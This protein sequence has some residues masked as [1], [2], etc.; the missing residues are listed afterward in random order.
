MIKENIIAMV[1]FITVSFCICAFFCVYIRYYFSGYILTD[2][3]Q[4]KSLNNKRICAIIYYYS[5]NLYSIFILVPHGDLSITSLTFFWFV[6]FIMILNVF[7]IS[8]LET[9]RRYKKRKKWK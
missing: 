3:Q 1:C 9:P 7:F 4:N 6:A 5:I 8:F 2:Y